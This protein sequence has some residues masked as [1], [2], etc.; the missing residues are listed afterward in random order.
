MMAEERTILLER[1]IG[2]A[3]EQKH[4]VDVTPP[5]MR[6]GRVYKLSNVSGHVSIKV[7]P[8]TIYQGHTKWIKF[9]SRAISWNWK[10]AMRY[11][12]EEY[13]MKSEIRCGGKKHRE[14]MRKY[15]G[16]KQKLK[17]IDES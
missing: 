10:A 12:S 3:K 2:W 5:N 17:E 15:I 1:L 16:R 8:Q 11:L 4:L 13:L 6:Q 7:S 9:E 14:A